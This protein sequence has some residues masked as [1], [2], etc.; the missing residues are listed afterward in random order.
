MGDTSFQATSQTG[1]DSNAQI[2]YDYSNATHVNY[3]S[4]TNTIPSNAWRAVVQ[5]HPST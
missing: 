5:S 3:V 4:G 1:Y 2:K